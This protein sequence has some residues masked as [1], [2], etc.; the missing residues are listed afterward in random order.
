M[1]GPPPTAHPWSEGKPRAGIRDEYTEGGV[2]VDVVAFE[3]SVIVLRDD[4]RFAVEAD[5]R[6]TR[7]AAATVGGPAR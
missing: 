6:V 7:A 5:L 4:L 3:P 1:S 2:I